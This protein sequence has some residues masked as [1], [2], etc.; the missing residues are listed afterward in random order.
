MKSNAAYNTGFEQKKN[1][2]RSVDFG[3]EI[4][5]EPFY[6]KADKQ[7]GLNSGFRPNELYGFN[8]KV[9]NLVA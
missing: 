6:G 5:K 3:R 7:V 1:R 9:D 4:E 8:L 2:L